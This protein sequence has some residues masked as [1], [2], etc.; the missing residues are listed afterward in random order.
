MSIATK[1]GDAGTTALLFGKR[2]PK[3]HLRVM[4]YGRI[5]ELTSVLGL[6]RAH[7]EIEG[8]KDLVHG[9]Q[10]ELIYLMSELATDDAD[11]ARFLEKYADQYISEKMVERLTV[12]IQTMESNDGGFAG[13][14]YPGNTIADAFFDQA[15][16]TC[17]RAERGV[18]ALKESG[19]IVRPELMQY[20]NRLADLLW[21]LGREHA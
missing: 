9:I 4:T 7:C 16:T 11:Q 3:T 1:T 19:A 15:R 14:T 5:D 20:L 2:V 13:W 21:L 10:K 18:V 8:T 12:T 17:R 6:C